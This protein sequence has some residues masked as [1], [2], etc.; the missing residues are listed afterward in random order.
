[1]DQKAREFRKGV[2]V[3]TSDDEDIELYEYVL[4]NRKRVLGSDHPDTLSSYSDL[5]NAYRSAGRIDEAIELYENLVPDRIR[6]LGEDHPQTLWTRCDLAE[7][8]KD[9]GRTDE[10]IELYEQ[11]IKELGSSDA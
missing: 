7:A 10:A 8:Y 6:V 3:S 5:A 2:H 1:V 11:I 4:A 9:A